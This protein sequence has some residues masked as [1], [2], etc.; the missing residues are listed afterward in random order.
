MKVDELLILDRG[1]FSEK[2][3]TLFRL[4][5]ESNP[6]REWFV[7]DPAEA[8]T[9]VLFPDQP[10]S[11]SRINQGNRVLLALLSNDKFLS[12]SRQFQ[13]R[14]EREIVQ[15]QG[16]DSSV[17]A[18]RTFIAT[19]DR[20]N[21]YRE[22]IDASMEFLDRETLFGLLVTDPDANDVTPDDPKLQP[23]CSVDIEICI[24]AVLIAAVFFVVTQID[25]NPL[26]VPEDLS[27]QDLQR[28]ANFISE[29]LPQRARELRA[30]GELV[31]FEAAKRGTTL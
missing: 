10:L 4:L 12:W 9:K 30:N 2:A 11:P 21:L 8:I 5:N 26:V 3:S 23:T 14:I 24:Y 19:I 1:D 16:D 27:R 13:A 15:A 28:V 31:S 6:Y 25:I 22:I 17:E 18:A 29:R 7:R 20:S